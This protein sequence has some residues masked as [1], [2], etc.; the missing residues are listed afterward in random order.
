MFILA[1]VLIYVTKKH[2]KEIELKNKIILEKEYEIAKLRQERF[3]LK[4]DLIDATLGGDHSYLK[5]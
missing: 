1:G 3:N 4:M 2:K 5:Y